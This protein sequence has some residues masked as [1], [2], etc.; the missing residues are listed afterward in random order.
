MS[1]NTY[2]CV[3]YPSADV[4]CL[5]VLRHIDN[6][7]HLDQTVKMGIPLCVQ[8]DTRKHTEKGKTYRTEKHEEINGYQRKER[9]KRKREGKR[10]DHFV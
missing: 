8:G 1:S 2:D 7:G 4:F 9:E 3:K 5:F 10:L 6:N